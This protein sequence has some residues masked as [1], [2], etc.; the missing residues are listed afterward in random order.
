MRSP[1]ATA[2]R[3]RRHRCALALV[4]V[5]VAMDVIFFKHRFWEMP[6]VQRSDCAGR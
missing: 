4:A 5:V 6:A 3:E 2:G 1:P